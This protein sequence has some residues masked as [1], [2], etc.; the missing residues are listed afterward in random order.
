LIGVIVYSPSYLNLKPRSM[1]FG[2]RYVYTSSDLHK[3]HLINEEIVRISRV[4]IHP[5]FR[6]IGLGAYLVKETLPKVGV[7]VV[8]ALA[9]MARYNPFFEKA[10]MIRVDYTRDSRS[11]DKEV[12]SFLESHNFDFDFVK[13][14]TYCNKFF[15]E[16]SSSDKQLLIEYLTDFA[17]Q[18][19]IKAKKIS[20]ELLTKLFN[21][22]ATY[23]YWINSSLVT[24]KS[25]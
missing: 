22:K 14:K 16:L 11:N 2:Q 4:V 10:G 3:A 24:R 20:P 9:V 25:C 15:A 8:E 21:S 23:L 6:G 18:P 17:S 7:K 19:F 12:R 1:V 5:K 13:S